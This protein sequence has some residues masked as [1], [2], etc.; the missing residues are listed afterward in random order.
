MKFLDQNPGAI[1][2]MANENVIFENHFFKFIDAGPSPKFAASGSK[3][4]R[5]K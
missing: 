4:H 5:R 3:K 2:K 1:N